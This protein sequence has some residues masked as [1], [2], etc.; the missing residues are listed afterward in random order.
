MCGTGVLSYEDASL[1]GQA[2]CAEMTF[3]LRRRWIP[4]PA[5]RRGGVVVGKREKENQEEGMAAAE[6]LGGDERGLFK[7]EH[8]HL[9]QLFGVEWILYLVA[10][11]LALLPCSN[12]G[13]RR[14]RCVEQNEW[15]REQKR[16]T[17]T[18]GSQTETFY[19][20][21]FQC[22][23]GIYIENFKE[24]EAKSLYK[25]TNIIFSPTIYII[26]LLNI[27]LNVLWIVLAEKAVLQLE[28]IWNIVSSCEHW[29]NN[30]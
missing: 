20:V 28:C 13:R 23:F 21:F 11:T 25:F 10:I 16:V 18:L 24:C 29:A 5:L 7:D 1:S 22:L 6:E 26:W 30:V 12:R 17:L 19:W 9:S 8:E 27:S 14:C 4:E 3:Q 2:V 15:Q